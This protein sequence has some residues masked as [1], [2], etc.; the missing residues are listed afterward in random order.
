MRKALACSMVFLALAAGAYAQSGPPHGVEFK[1]PNEVET[2]L[3]KVL[4]T[5]NKAQTNRYVPKVYDLKNVNPYDVLRFIVRPM[6]IEEGAWFLF[7]KPEDPG[8]PDSVKS[9]KVVVMAPTYQIPYLDELMEVIDAPGLTTSSGDKMFYY[10]PKHRYVSDPDF[11]DLVEAVLTPQHSGG[12]QVTDDEVNGFLFYDSPSGI[13]DIERWLPII[14]QPPPQVMVEATIYEINIENDD[15]IGLDYVAWKD[16]PGRNLF[17]AGFYWEKEHIRSRK[18]KGIGGLPPVP[19][20]SGFGGTWGLPGHRFS[21][22]GKHSSYMIDIPSSFFDY[23]VTKQKARVLTSAKVLARNNQPAVLAVADRIFYWRDLDDGRCV[24]GGD[25][26]REL[27]SGLTAATAGVFLEVTPLV[28]SEGVNLDVD[29]MVVSHT[30]F[31]SSGAPLLAGR[32]FSTSL[33]VK[34]GEE[35]ILGGYTREVMVQRPAR[36][37]CWG[38]CRSSATSSAARRTWSSADSSSSCSAPTSSGISRR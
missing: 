20:P 18:Y 26:E 34:D 17:T 9:G 4:R 6:Q 16:G 32:D 8:D 10:R 33:R 7:G 38:A 1:A 24:S 14:D 5:T 19:T 35:V 23:L 28:G 25:E 30:G 27:P 36:S 12:D 11:E 29:F 31:E 37:P 22:R 3:I 13:E 21:T 15:R 2:H